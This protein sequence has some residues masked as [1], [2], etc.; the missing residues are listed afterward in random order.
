LSSWVSSLKNWRKSI[1]II[2][3]ILLILPVYSNS[4]TAAWQF[5]DKPNIIDNHY[6]HLRDLKPES[7][8]QTFYTKPTDPSN[9]GARLYRPIAF[10]TFALNWYFGKDNVVGYH[11]VN[12]LIH[13]LTSVFLFLAILSLL[14]APNLSRQIER[15]RYLIA[16]ISA[17]LWS[18]NPIQTQA[19]TYIVQRMASMAAMFYILSML[20]YIKCRM[21]QSSSH[22]ILL[23][24][25]CALSFLMALGSKENAAALLAA[26]LL[27][28][29]T[30][31]QD[32]NWR[33]K[34]T[35]FWGG[36]IAG[37]VL[38][39]LGGVWLFRPDVFISFFNGYEARPYTFSE[40]LLTEPRI[41]WYYLS[42]IF[43]PIP[44]RLSIEHDV[45]ISTSLFQ[46]WT[47]LPAILLTLLTIGFAISQVRKRPLIALAI[48]FFFLN[49]IIESTVFPLELIFEHRN[50][51][52]SMFLF[53]PLA[54]GFK[55]LYDY[56]SIHNR[57]LSGALAGFLILL[58]ACLGAGT[59]IRNS[60]WATEFS[61][62]QDAMSKAPQ[63]ARPLTNLGWQLAY[64]PDA[65]PSQYDLALKLYEKAFFL[66]KP[67]SFSESIIM[68]NLAG[69]YFK[70]EEHQKAIDLLERALAISPAYARG[71]HDLVRILV[72]NGQWNRASE[73]I[74]YLLSKHD[75]HEGYLNMKGL[76]LLHQK[77]YA[78]AVKY[79]RKA[80]I[81]APFF[82]DALM[83]L[84]IAYSS[85]GDY[86]KA[87]MFLWRAHRVHPRN[88]L[89]L[90][91]LIENN[92]RAGDVLQAK[93]YT[94]DLISFYKMSAVK[95]QLLN[96]SANNLLPPLS[97][98]LI[99]TFMK[100][101]FLKPAGE[102]SLTQN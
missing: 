36:G 29:M 54:V 10:L 67:R 55:W 97:P 98:E 82:K 89:P 3:L 79:F 66:Q 100:S 37:G 32:L 20:L 14:E 31:F 49:H 13:C 69:I 65:R 28:E 94:G 42:Q 88:M 96:I 73:H 95:N 56:Y 35:L 18:L 93:A 17:A 43:Y 9:P 59:Y 45:V 21:S 62:W 8:I 101:Q 81:A 44:T 25:G 75:A 39:F 6:L 16:F 7:L 53:L 19:V 47:T 72:A 5:D 71:R 33:Q 12:F 84:G 64:G 74:D 83:N 50:Y 22:R 68:N 60:T 46:P 27:I 102:I 85:K 86:R 78:E 26:L 80:L 76:I 2:L 87:E 77:K 51:L 61:L 11:V 90:L 34:K 15:N 63:S 41:V 48:L 24:L 91:G 30:F 58:I 70:K 99:L 57:I 38:I 4:F 23:L 40:R 1:V 52:P 92:L